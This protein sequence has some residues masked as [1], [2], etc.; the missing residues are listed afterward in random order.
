MCICVIFWILLS[1][2]CEYLMYF[3][4]CFTFFLDFV[5]C[6]QG[7]NGSYAFSHLTGRWNETMFDLPLPSCTYEEQITELHAGKVSQ[8]Q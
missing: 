8:Q 7:C 5:V 1:N 2:N 6:N 3:L 4:I